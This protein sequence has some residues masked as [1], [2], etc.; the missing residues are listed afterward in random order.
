[1]PDC[2]AAILFAVLL[3]P[4][5]GS[6]DRPNTVENKVSEIRSTK[7]RRNK[8]VPSLTS[9]NLFSDALSIVLVLVKRLDNCKGDRV[10]SLGGIDYVAMPILAVVVNDP[11]QNRLDMI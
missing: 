8:W 11:L 7:T 10:V 1:M 9:L 5:L 4:L 2:S 3:S 6:S